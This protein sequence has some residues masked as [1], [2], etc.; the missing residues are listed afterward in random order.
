MAPE[1]HIL[2]EYLDSLM[3]EPC[4]GTLEESICTVMAFIA[5]QDNLQKEYR[6]STSLS[7][8]F[9]IQA[10]LRIVSLY[11]LKTFGSEFV[12]AVKRTE[13]SEELEAKWKKWKNVA[14]PPIQSG[15][16]NIL[17]AE[18]SA[19]HLEDVAIV[20]ALLDLRVR[21]NHRSNSLTDPNDSKPYEDLIDQI[22]VFLCKF[23]LEFVNAKHEA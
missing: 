8:L 5:V 3:K 21:L 13:S 10:K 18:P 4:P 20:N 15:L 9:D 12:D 22:S 16:G 19:N 1:K 11:L 23:P 14:Q 2:N 6:A 7:Y 17:T